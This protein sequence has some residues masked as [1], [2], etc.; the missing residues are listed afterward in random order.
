MVL[1]VIF[2]R[3]YIRPLLPVT[4]MKVG[5]EMVSFNTHFFDQEEELDEIKVRLYKQ[6]N[7]NATLTR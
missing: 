5:Q 1:F 3:K 6:I 7:R 2:F 4:I